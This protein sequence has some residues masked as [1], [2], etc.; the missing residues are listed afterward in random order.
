MQAIN[1]LHDFFQRSGAEVRLYHL[2]RRV[3]PCPLE[4]LAAFEAG[5]RPGRRRGRVAR[6][7]PWSFAWATWTTR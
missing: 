1:S 6:A 5:E 7:W 4:T 2:G 3:E